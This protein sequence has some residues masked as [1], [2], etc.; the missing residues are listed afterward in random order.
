MDHDIVARSYLPSPVG[1]IKITSTALG[2]G[3][4][5][6]SNEL[7]D[8][9]IE[10]GPAHHQLAISQ[11]ATYFEG[12]LKHFSFS[13]DLRGTDFQLKVWQELQNI[14]WGQ[15][16][17]YKQ[18]ALQM[19]DVHTIRAVGRAN[20]QN[21]LAIVVPCH[22]VIGADGSLVGYAGGIERKEW[23]LRHE[24]ALKQLPLFES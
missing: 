7:E 17:S 23:L 6:F 18:L 1:Q 19:G 8:A 15:T 4:I 5:S 21:P 2:V 24:G 10:P 3:E 9:A 22:R 13:I 16:I 20:G 14:P 11:L 12:S